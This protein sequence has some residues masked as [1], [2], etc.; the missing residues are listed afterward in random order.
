MSKTKPKRK[1]TA[2]E[3]WLKENGYKC[4]SYKDSNGDKAYVSCNHKDEI[5]YWSKE[6]LSQPFRKVSAERRENDH[7]V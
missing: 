3:I 4:Y 1:K 6:K 5:V 7:E 2:I